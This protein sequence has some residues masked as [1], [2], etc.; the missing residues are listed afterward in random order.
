MKVL[1]VASSN[2][3]PP[4]LENFWKQFSSFHEVTYHY[5]SLSKKPF[6]TDFHQYV[7]Q[8]DFSIYDRIIVQQN[9]RRIG[10]QYTALRLIPNLVFFESDTCQN[11]IPESK[12]YKKFDAIFRDIGDVRVVVTSLF[13]QKE[14]SKLSIDC[15]YLPKACDESTISNL[16]TER[17]IEFGF[18]GKAENRV[19]KKRR[20]ILDAIKTKFGLKLL[21][22]EPG[23]EYNLMLNRIRFFFSADI[24]FNEYMFK[25]FEAMCAGCVVFA[26]RQPEYEQQALGF[27][28]MENIVLYDSL[29]EIESKYRI[30][31]NNPSLAEK[32]SQSARQLVL[33]HHTFRHRAASLATIVIEDIVSGP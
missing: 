18:I 5:I 29:D 22:T 14:F 17:D 1:V 8:T 4:S 3:N 28:D 15:K 2:S 27:I 20:Q 11:Y 13:V 33:E 6:A 16:E 12:F 7:K 23:E 32:I 19:Y 25:N 26:K 21:R 24:G 30:L 31:K 10:R 9:L